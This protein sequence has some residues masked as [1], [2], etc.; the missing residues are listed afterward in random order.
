MPAL[1]PLASAKQS[2]SLPVPSTLDMHLNGK[3]EILQKG[4]S[5]SS[6]GLFLLFLVFQ[7]A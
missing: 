3:I 7:L 1:E 5:C 2:L 6:V 4:E